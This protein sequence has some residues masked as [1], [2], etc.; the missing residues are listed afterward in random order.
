MNKAV[1]F[2]KLDFITIKPYLTLKNLAIFGVLAVVF[3]LLYGNGVVSVMMI[4]I[5][6]VM[7]SNYP[8]MTGEKSNIDALYITL[9]IK[10]KTVVLGRYIFAASINIAAGLISCVFSWAFQLVLGQKNNT[11]EIPVLTAVML[12]VYSLIQ[13]VQFPLYFKLGYAKAKVMA[14]LPF[15][16]MFVGSV[17]IGQLFSDGGTPQTFAGSLGW[18]IKNP[19]WAAA[20]GAGVW[21]LL[22]MLSYQL[23]L[24]YYK[25]REF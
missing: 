18:F 19:G 10:R 1:S 12:V 13:A 7:Y 20:F 16:G 6:A 9:S 14:Y 4:I 17:V 21:I 22:M 8:F 2:V 25:Q 11:F 15:I 24:K 3:S 5:C 23:S